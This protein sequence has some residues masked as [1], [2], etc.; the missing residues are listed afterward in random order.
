MA[1]EGASFE[2]DLLQTT[3][4]NV[5]SG[6]YEPQICDVLVKESAIILKRG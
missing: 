5:V 1:V 2:L 6:V 4:R 3:H